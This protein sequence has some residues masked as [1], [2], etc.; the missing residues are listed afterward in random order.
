MRYIDMSGTR[1]ANF[2][3]TQTL[4]LLKDYTN[5]QWQTRK[6]Y[7]QIYI[8]TFYHEAGKGEK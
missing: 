8:T 4:M 3:I 1:S 5:T 6:K 2:M 7:L